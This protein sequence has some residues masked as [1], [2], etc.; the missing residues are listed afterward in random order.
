M[1]L[2]RLTALFVFLLAALSL[3]A[4]IAIYGDTRTNDDIHSKIITAISSHKPRIAFHSGDL[5]DKGIVQAEYDKFFEISLPLTRLCNIHPAKGNHERD[6]A[7]FL[8]NFPAIGEKTYYSVAYDG[9]LFL[10]LDSTIDLKPESEQY[11]W[12]E[13]ELAANTQIPA[14]IIIHHPVFSSGAHGDE[15]GLALFLPALFERHNVR[16]V[17]SGHDHNYERSEFGGIAYITTGGGGAPLRDAKHANPHSIIFQKEHHYCIGER[18]EDML[19]F[20]VYDL[21]GDVLDDFLIHL[22]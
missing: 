21:S 11:K 20:E 1:K 8:K 6:A 18:I 12:L 19:F 14:I 17:F 13:R 3:S 22:R 2:F 4:Q 7:L 5:G 9:M 10:L 15:L 16:A